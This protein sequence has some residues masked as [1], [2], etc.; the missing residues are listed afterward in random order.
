[1]IYVLEKV[2]SVRNNLV[3]PLRAS[4]VNRSIDKWTKTLRQLEDYQMPKEP[5]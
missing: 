5:F 3:V 1:M 4:R 2:D